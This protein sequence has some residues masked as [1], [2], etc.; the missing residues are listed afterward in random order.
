MLDRVTSMQVFVRVV[1]QGSFAAA[2]RTL[3][4]SQTMVTRHI[5]ALEERLGVTLFQRS[6]RRLSLTE[7]GQRYLAG[8]QRVLGDL[9]EME[10]EV[11]AEGRE[12]R[13]RL[14]L[15]APV[16]FAIRYL[17]PVLPE[18][19]RRY[20][21][22]SVELGLDDGL[23]DLIAQGWDLT[24][25]IRRMEASSLKARRLAS[26]CYV[27]CAAPSYLNRYGEPKTVAELEIHMCLGY[28][29]SEAVGVG[30]W[31]FGRDGEVTVPVSG[32]L[33][34]NNG[35]VL[36]QAALAGMGII[37][38]PLFIVAEAVRRGDLKVLD[39]GMP[40]LEGPE[41]Q[42]VYAP[43]LTVPLKTRVMI[44]YLVECFGERPPWEL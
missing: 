21:K 11:A 39:L 35:D 32:P 30:R 42:A 16:S 44:D 20:P 26:I 7:A 29:L 24:L 6:T 34:A 43:G 15:N 25:R 9:D 2:A 27:V 12:P 40:L 17:G 28:T 41:L 37:Y 10:H 8:C 18:F 4:L 33:S 5:V 1:S 23:V 36:T 31:S 3:S 38:Q 19:S 22:V 14:R 13:G